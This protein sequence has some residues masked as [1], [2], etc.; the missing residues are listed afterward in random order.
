MN[1][2]AVYQRLA[3]VGAALAANENPDADRKALIF[4]ARAERLAQEKAATP[5]GTRHE[6]LEFQ[7]GSESYCIET[8]YVEEVCPLKD[9]TDLPGTP[10]FV[11]GL[12]NVRGRILSLVNIKAFFAL[13]EQSVSETSK[14]MILRD[15][16]MEFGVLADEIIGVTE[17]ARQDIEPLLATLEEKRGEWLSGITRCGCAVIDARQL[18]TD[19]RI[20]V[21]DEV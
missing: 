8:A 21:D 10:P 11:A 2:E 4:K 19:A 7:L 6:M 13:T 9:Y 18:L 15:G 14:V 20:I 17:V 12:I 16:E 5:E 1:W 3:A